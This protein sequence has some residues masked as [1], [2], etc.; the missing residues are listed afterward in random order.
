MRASNWL[1]F[2]LLAALA[3]APTTAPSSND[4]DALIVQLGHD[5]FKVREEASTKLAKIGKPALSALQKA[6]TSGDPEVQSRAQMLIKR[7]EQRPVPGGPVNPDDPVVA[8]S[9]RISNDGATK[10][11]EVRENQRTIT[12]REK[13]GGIVMTVSAIENGRRPPATNASSSSRIIS[14]PATSCAQSSRR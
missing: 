13:T 10:N 7:I 12:I 2:L 4:V 5:D 8:R 11:I 3:A 9:L 6:L 1:I 14:R